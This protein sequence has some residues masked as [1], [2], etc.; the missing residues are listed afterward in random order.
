[1]GVT[2]QMEDFSLG[3]FRR[4]VKQKAFDKFIYNYE[5]QDHIDIGGCNLIAHF[6]S[7]DI[8]TSPNSMVFRNNH[9]SFVIENVISVSLIE[10]DFVLGDVFAVN[11]VNRDKK[12]KKIFIAR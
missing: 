8:F 12:Y 9:T 6:R 1:M 3:K 11:Y 10:Q 5:N 4:Y 2:L 7:V